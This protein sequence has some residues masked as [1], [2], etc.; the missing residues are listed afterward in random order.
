M[1]KITFSQAMHGYL[2]TIG[3]RHLSEH[4]LK[5]YVKTFNRFSTFLGEDLPFEDI[6]HKQIEAFI[7]ALLFYV[8][9]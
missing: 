2:L 1:S 9:E 6:T 4:T 3:A 5:S 7:S 8:K